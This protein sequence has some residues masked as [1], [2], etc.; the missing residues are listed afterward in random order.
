[1]ADDRDQRE[2]ERVPKCVPVRLRFQGAEEFLRAYTENISLGGVFVPTNV[3]VPH[4]T[5]IALTIELTPG[6]GLSVQAEVA[7]RREPGGK[8][9]PGVGLRFTVV[10]PKHRRWLDEAVG[11]KAEASNKALDIE[12]TPLLRRAQAADVLSDAHL[13]LDTVDFP[14]GSEPVIGIDLGTSNSC[15]AIF[16]QDRAWVIDLHPG[17]EGEAPSTTIP[18]VVAYDANGSMSVGR[19][20]LD[21]LYHNP[22]GTIFASKRFI[23]RS[24]DHPDVH[25]LLSRYPYK[26]VPGAGRKVAVEVNGRAMS[27]TSVSA[28]ILAHVK[29]QAEAALKLPI[30][31]AIITVPAYYNQNQRDAVVQAGRLAGLTVERIINEPTAAAIAYGFM[32]DGKGQG[33]VLVYDLGGGTFDVSVVG[34]SPGNLK[35]MSTAGD[36]FLGGEDFDHAIVEHVRTQFEEESG[37]RVS[38]NHAATALLTAA[39]EAAKVRL[40]EHEQSMV[41]VRELLMADGSTQRLEVLLTRTVLEDL[42]APLVQRTLDICDM[43]L[44]EVGLFAQA[45][46]EVILVGGQIRMPYIQKRV[47]RH[48]GREARSDIPPDEVVAL[49]AGLLT[50]LNSMP[51]GPGL[52]DALSMSIGTAGDDDTFERVF[53]RNSTLPASQSL[54]LKVSAKDLSHK[55]VKVYQGEHSL[56]SRNAYLGEIALSEV[57]GGGD[58]VVVRIDFTLS[59]DCLLK[60]QLTNVANDKTVDVLLDT[61][62][63]GL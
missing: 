30:A 16:W 47:E 24:Y 61:A 13:N 33:T 60:V 10:D 28:K 48:F 3:E 59:P 37:Q 42:V 17:E 29:K 52:E 25:R 19:A 63:S 31:K 1:M 22:N 54:R 41:V 21:G 55:K 26:V 36:T 44:G 23:G 53:P 46:D 27:L 32:S 40:S 57:T 35:I 8:F 49:G 5:I 34:V 45:V 43:A 2:Y 18:S 39:A 6:K 12:R 62:D 9:P 51:D 38:R 56:C 14:Q 15:A 58:I 50:H 11:K 20:A 7:W 4:G